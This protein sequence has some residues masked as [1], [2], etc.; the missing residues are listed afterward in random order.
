[1]SW[2]DGGLIPDASQNAAQKVFQRAVVGADQANKN[3]VAVL[4]VDAPAK[5]VDISG[6]NFV[7]KGDRVLEKGTS[8]GSN[9]TTTL[10]DTTKTWTVNGW[11]GKS[12]RII[13]GVGI[14]QEKVVASNTA[15]ALTITG[16]WV[17]TPD[18]T[19]HYEIFDL[20]GN[21]ISQT[22]TSPKT[23]MDVE[24]GLL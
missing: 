18:A 21:V 3:N 19:S 1:M 17:T 9:T 12:V 7:E 22:D 10:K 20:V 14:G 13:A 23:S 8:S 4:S 6:T 2:Q 15:T 11:T 24:Y 16:L 5:I